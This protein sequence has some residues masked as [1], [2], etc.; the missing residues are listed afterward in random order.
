MIEVVRRKVARTGVASLEWFPGCGYFQRKLTVKADAWCVAESGKVLTECRS[1][2]IAERIA[3]ALEME[4][5]K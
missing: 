2:A 4:V 1:K 5:T 3:S